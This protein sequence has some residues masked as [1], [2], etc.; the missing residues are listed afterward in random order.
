MNASARDAWLVSEHIDV[1]VGLS[2]VFD[3]ISR[4]QQRG[5]QALELVLCSHEL[6]R[7]QG[8]N[9]TL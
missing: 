5:C 1:L 3:F 8:N 2:K 4:S 9:Q 7:A 6:R